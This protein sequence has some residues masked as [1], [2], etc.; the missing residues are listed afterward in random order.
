MTFSF[1]SSLRISEEGG[2][3]SEASQ[4]SLDDAVSVVKAKISHALVR[5]TLSTDL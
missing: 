5:N 3:G 4:S 1:D 2:R